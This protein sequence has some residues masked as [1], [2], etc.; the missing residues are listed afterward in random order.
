[1]WQAAQVSI[2]GISGVMIAI[3]LLYLTVRVSGHITAKIEK[4][5]GKADE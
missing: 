1:M 5:G 4:K 2:A 3:C